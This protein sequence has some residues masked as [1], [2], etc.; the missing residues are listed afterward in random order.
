MGSVLKGWLA[1]IIE[2]RLGNDLEETI[3]EFD[4]M[5]SPLPFTA[6][7]IGCSLQTLYRWRAKLNYEKRK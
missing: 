6:K 5:Q 1:K 4:K 2:A 7:E 3:E